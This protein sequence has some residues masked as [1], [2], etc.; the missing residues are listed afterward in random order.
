MDADTVPER[1][2]LTAD[3]DLLL[4]AWQ[5][6]MMQRDI[7]ADTGRHGTSKRVV[8]DEF[9]RDALTTLRG[10]GRHDY[11]HLAVADAAGAIVS[12]RARAGESDTHAGTEQSNHT[13]AGTASFALLEDAGPDL[14]RHLAS[15]SRSLLLLIDLYGFEP[16]TDGKWGVKR[17]QS[18]LREAC[19]AFPKLRE[20]DL[21]AVVTAYRDAIKALTTKSMSWRKLALVGAGGLGLGVLTGGLAAPVIGGV[22]GTAVLGYTGAAATSAGLAALGGGSIAA[23]GF[24]MAGGAAFIAGAGGV[25]GAGAAATAAHSARFTTGQVV[26]DV[27]RLQVVTRM[28]FIDTEGDDEA[29]K[30]VAVALR[31]K[32]AVLAKKA[33]ELARRVAEVRR[34]LDEARAEAGRQQEARLAAEGRLARLQAD[35]ERF[36]REQVTRESSNKMVGTLELLLRETQHEQKATEL[37]AEVVESGAERIEEAA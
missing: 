11:A 9:R 20:E 15:R 12:R 13:T 22:F 35:V 6:R 24:G 19:A 4:T 10:R 8:R 27:V 14:A 31:E 26:A 5:Y 3:E 7:A 23:G 21:T 34:Q 37:A 1:L 30:A 25:A 2:T 18:S 16:W 36:V 33:A 17:R 32:Y 29:A 28:V